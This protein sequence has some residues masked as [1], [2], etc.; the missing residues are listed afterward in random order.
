MDHAHPSLETIA[1][2]QRFPTCGPRTTGG[3]Q[4]NS[5]KQTKINKI[6]KNYANLRLKLT[7]IQPDIQQL[8]KGRQAQS[9]H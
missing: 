1:L 9:S 8:C 3:P 2:E 4:V 7:S 6:K 5:N